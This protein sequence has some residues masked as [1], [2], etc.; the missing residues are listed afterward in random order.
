MTRLL[1]VLLLLCLPARADSGPKGLI[2]QE[3]RISSEAPAWLR[4]AALRGAT[5]W[6][7]AHP[8]F[9]RRFRT[10]EPAMANI[11]IGPAPA[12]LV[13]VTYLSPDF[14]PFIMVNEVDVEHLS[15]HRED[16]FALLLH[17]M[18]HALCGC[19]AHLTDTSAGVMSFELAK[20]TPHFPTERDV[21]LL[22]KA[23]Q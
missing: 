3:W 8:A 16:A 9:Q 11:G 21:A 14:Y 5:L 20:D 10:V 4:R 6:G 2:I 23:M 22:R 15:T 12:E 18:G 13:A 17:E 7:K 19:D 1:L